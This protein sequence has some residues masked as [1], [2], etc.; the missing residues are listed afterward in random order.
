M[1]LIMSLRNRQNNNELD[2]CNGPW[3]DYEG[4][5]LFSKKIVTEVDAF[6]E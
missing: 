4:Q 1:R 3:Y 2:F 5:Q 6:C